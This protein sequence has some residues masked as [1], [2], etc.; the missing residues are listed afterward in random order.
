MDVVFNQVKVLRTKLTTKSSFLVLQLFA[1]CLI[2]LTRYRLRWY[3]Q[4]VQ[5][6]GGRGQVMK[7]TVW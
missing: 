1:L 7:L 6:E 4:T 2:Q 3:N 5:K